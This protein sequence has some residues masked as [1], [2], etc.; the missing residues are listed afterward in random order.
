MTLLPPTQAEEHLSQVA[1]Q[2]AQW[3]Q[4]RANP[5]GSRIPEPLWAEAITL[6][7]VL[8]ATQVARHLGLKP[9]AL[10]RRR[11]DHDSPS[12]T[13]RPARAAAFVEVTTEARRGATTEVEI[14]RPDG[15]RLRS[16]SHGA[17][18]ALTPLLRKRSTKDVIDGADQDPS[19][20][21]CPRS[22]VS[23]GEG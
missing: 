12:V 5:R 18:P 8:P 21:D 14:Q 2:V 10:K 20:G 6:A 9:H 1:Q 16:T 11:G 19:A 23:T 13:A 3:R 17:A 15:R 4:S 7:E 22:A